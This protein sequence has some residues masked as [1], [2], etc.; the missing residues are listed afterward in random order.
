MFLLDTL[1]NLPRMRISNSLMNVFLWVLREAGTHNVPSLYHL[2]Q[3]QASLQK[4]SGVPTTQHKS[5]KGNI[6]SMNDPWTLVAMDW[7]NPTVCDYICRYPVI[8]LDGVIS[9]VYHAQKWRKDVD[10]HTL[11]PMYDAGDRHYY[12]DELVP[13]KDDAYVITFDNQFAANVVDND[14][15]LIKASDLQDNLLDLRDLGLLPTTWNNQTINSGHPAHMPNSDRALAEGDPLYSSWIDIFGDNVSGNQSKSWNKHWNTYISHQNLPQ[16][17]LQQEFHTH[18]ISTSPVASIPEQFHGI[19]QV[20]ESTHKKPVKVRHGTSGAQIWL[21]I[22]VNCGPGDNPAQSK[23]C[24]HIGGNG[25]HLCRKCLV[26]RPQQ[27][28]ETD[29]GFHSLFQAGVARSAEGILSDVKSQ[30]ELACLGIA[31]NVQ[32]QQTKNG[33]KDGYTQF[34]IDDLVACA[35]TLRKNHPERTTVDIQTELL[36]WVH[37]NK[38]DIYNPFLTLDGFDPALDTPVEILHTILLGIVKYLWHGSHTPW[39]VSQKQ[40]YSVRLQST[41]RSGLSIHAICA[42]YIMQYANSLIGQQFKTIAQVNVFHVYDLVD[43][44][45]FLLTR[46]SDIEVAAANVL[47]LFAMIDPSKMMSKVKLHLLVH[48]KSDILHFGPLVGV[49]TEVFE[50]FNAIFRF[51][52]IFSNHLAPS[53][54]IAFQLAGQEVLK[55]CLT[56]GWWSTADGEWERPGPSV[57]NFIHAHLTLQALVGWTSAELLVLSDWNHSS[58][59]QYIPWFLT[60]GVKALNSLEDANSQWTPCQFAVARSGVKCL[61]GSWIFARSPLNDSELITGRIVEILANTT[62]DHAVIVLDIFKVLST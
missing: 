14:M 20:I 46:A 27:F 8:P 56:G 25:N 41:E 9:E 61:V 32:N 52:S 62:G 47:D 50:C 22:Y 18:F 24:G 31:H 21:K 43:T 54:D 19:K 17:F 48:L 15:I 2:C 16:K 58:K 1:D 33:I 49:A 44:I 3:V 55:H 4:S 6:Y 7:A 35:R 57:H 30:V 38:S 42:N 29:I 53:Q 13:L 11:S 45:Q 40:T 34:W 39:T 37:K 12:I 51:C 28:K 60:Q 5:P 23:V 59:M 26:G 36:T 10:Q